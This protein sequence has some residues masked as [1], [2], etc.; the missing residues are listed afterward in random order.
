M[1]ETLG[2][3]SDSP[4]D[5]SPGLHSQGPVAARLTRPVSRGT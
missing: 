3:G 5:L 4:S 1:S 2:P